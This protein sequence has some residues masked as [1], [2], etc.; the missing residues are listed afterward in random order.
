MPL[1]HVRRLFIAASLA[2]SAH[3]HAAVAPGLADI[4]ALALERLDTE[5]SYTT[6][7][8]GLEAV[9][10]ARQAAREYLLGLFQDDAFVQAT[11]AWLRSHRPA[12]RDE[13]YGAWVRHYRETLLA[14]LALLS[15]DEL[16]F[17]WRSAV[18]RTALDQDTCVK[19]STGGADTDV[20]ALVKYP[21]SEL[22]D[23]FRILR[24]VYLAALA[25]EVPRP[26]PQEQEL[27]SASLRLLTQ[28]PEADRERLLR[29][30]SQASPGSAEEECA[31]TRIYVSALNAAPGE[32][33][34][35]LRRDHLVHGMRAAIEAPEAAGSTRSVR[36]AAT[37]EFEPGAVALE[38]PP[39]AARAG[40]EGSMRIR[41]WVDERGRA[42]RVRT[43][44]RHFNKPA[45]TLADGS[46]VGVEEMFD[47]I[48]TVFYKAGRFMQR[49]KDGKPQPYV[50]EIPLSWKLE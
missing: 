31:T 12:S 43:I 20:A 29:R 40:I 46:Q 45:A 9:P 28:V 15:D 8:G 19:L 41:V 50:V 18:F 37:G 14:G 2:L 13:A 16:A 42:T 6:V 25:N 27:A 32:A 4:R 48:V 33:G 38:Y 17:I 7:V 5:P 36:G 34:R 11:A 30:W 10:D 47:P 21:A 39:E 1:P 23:Y 35:L 26:M 24:R 44:E 49:F 22:R 3:G